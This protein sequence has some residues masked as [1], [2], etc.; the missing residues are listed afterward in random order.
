MAHRQSL[1][2]PVFCHWTFIAQRTVIAIS[3]PVINST[4]WI[5][6]LR[7]KAYTDQT[8]TAYMRVYGVTKV[9]AQ[10]LC[11]TLECELR[12]LISK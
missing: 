4:S 3:I 12:A 6:A 5:T 11:Y 7:W 9:H 10:L 2:A 1:K 8:S